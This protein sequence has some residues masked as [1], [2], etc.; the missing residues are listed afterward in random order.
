MRLKSLF[1]RTSADRDLDAELRFHVDQAIAQNLARGMGREEARRAALFEFGGVAAISEEC[2]EARR[3]NWFHDLLQD[4]RY[5]AR[6]LRKSPGFTAT[7]LVTLA[8]GIGACTAVFSLVNSILLKPLLFPHPEEI[9]YL[10]HLNYPG[11]LI[12]Y[13]QFPWS[14]MEVQEFATTHRSLKYFGAFEPRRFNLTG[15]G[16]PVTLRGVRATAGFFP[17]LGVAPALGRVFT[18]EEDQPGND[19][20]VVVSDRLWRERFAADPGAVGRTMNLNNT[21]YTIIGVMPQGFAFPR[22]AEMSATFM[23]AS[24]T[25]VWVPA[26]LPANARGLS[27]FAAIGRAQPGVSVGKV[28]AELKLFT[29]REDSEY[30]AWKGWYL[31]DASPLSEEIS[32]RVSRPLLLIMGSVAVVLLIACANVAGLLLSHAI[33]RR[34]EFSLRAALGAG[35]G[36]IVRQ[37]L[38]ESVLFSLL[39]GL[40]GVAISIAMMAFAKAF[41]PAGIPRLAEVHLDWRVLIFALAVS[42]A[43]GAIF[44]L[45]PALGAANTNLTESLKESSQKATTS[46]LGRFLHRALLVAEISLALVLAVAAGLLVRTFIS[47]LQ[48]DPGFRPERVVSFPVT[49]SPLKYSD[50]ARMAEFYHAALD[51][52]RSLPGILSAALTE[53]LPMGDLPDGTVIRING[54]QVF[55]EKNQP[56]ANYT[57]VSPGFFEAIGVPLERGRDINDFDTASTPSVA[58]INQAMARTY[59]PGQ[60]AIGK[61]VGFGSPRMPLVTIVGIVADS[62]QASLRETPGPSMFIPYQQKPWS[63]MSTMHFVLRTKADA[64]SIVSDAQNALHSIDADVPMGKAITLSTLIDESLA[65]ARFAMLLLAGLAGTALVLASVGLYG[66]ISYSVAQRT[67]EIGIRMA[68]GAEPR[69]ILNMVLGGGARLAGLGIAIG[70]VAALGAA[71]LMS[72]F[73]YGVRATDPL[74]FAAVSFLLLAVSLVASF[75]P[76]RR[77]MRV[78]PMVTLRFE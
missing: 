24:E 17:T 21:L 2:R 71:H 64:S 30:P 9:V 48:G 37:L 61:Q 74:T 14:P 49:L 53:T 8:L 27:E 70:L 38:T 51:K 72:S 23:F 7:A 78:D 42:L 28:R 66:V 40:A 26:A 77:A 1:R 67:Q 25:A 34:R 20:V 22:A 13:D 52:L 55:N 29:D 63:P 58:V 76:A 60:D 31:Y 65:P 43:S 39:G 11:A 33:G 45:A 36:R 4:S 18:A 73:L 16:Q 12:G 35:T 56:Y 6:I 44:G 59:W 50:T 46:R 15:T 10:K 41:A 62:K 47:M 5:A 57:I 3:V 75:A 32:G 54:S 68:L 69:D 19:H